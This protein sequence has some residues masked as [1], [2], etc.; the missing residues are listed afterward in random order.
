MAWYNNLFG[1]GNNRL[2]E[3]IKAFKGKD[4]E[5]NL[6]PSDFKSKTGEGI[7]D[8]ALMQMGGYGAQGIGG[9]NSFYNSYIN[10]SFENA[11]NKHSWRWLYR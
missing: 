6:T 10:R 3:Q 11:G 8:V 7:E 5:A 9:F 2:D 4:E 1:G